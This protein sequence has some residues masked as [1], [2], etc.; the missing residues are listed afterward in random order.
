LFAVPPAND[1]NNKRNS[2]QQFIYSFGGD[3]Q[4]DADNRGGGV[5]RTNWRYDLSS[6]CWERLTDAPTEI[7]YRA[8]ATQVTS[9]PDTVYVIAGADG[10]RVAMNNVY[11]Y[12]LAQDTWTL[13]TTSSRNN[14]SSSSD[15]GQLPAPRWKHAAVAL[16]E[17]RILVTGGRQGATVHADVWILD[18]ASL[19]WMEIDTAASGSPMPPVY[20]HGMAWDDRR[21][22]AWIYG[23]LDD[24]LTRYASQLWRLNVTAGSVDQVSYTSGDDDPPPRMASHAMEYVSALDVLILWGGNCGDDSALHVYDIASSTWCRIFPATRPDQR[25]AMLWAL[26]YPQFY[27]AGGDILCYNGQILPISDV[28][29]LDLTKV[30]DDNINAAWT[31]L[32]EPSN[33]R[34]TGN[35]PFCT[36]SNAG[37][38][39]PR[40]LLADTVGATSTCAA[41]VMARFGNGTFVDTTMSPVDTTAR[42]SA[43]M[44]PSSAPLWQ[45]LTGMWLLLW[46]AANVV[47]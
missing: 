17:T 6:G 44:V 22:V 4:S 13:L 5:V 41:D 38:C 1:I 11:S 15:G 42:P 47:R 33:T 14:N 21:N 18:T 24:R 27:I 34:G 31:M 30:D 39:Q 43:P 28:H 32:Y 3:T 2:S 35:E 12:S 20:R 8:T 36:G 25:D 46:V 40:P 19:T 23:G 26:D 45:S 37:N 7:G 16:D 9:Q 10:S 29:V